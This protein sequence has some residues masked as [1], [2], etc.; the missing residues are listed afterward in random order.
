MSL[1]LHRRRLLK[2]VAGGALV[3]S[4]LAAC[5]RSGGAALP[6]T[7]IGAELAV[8]AAVGGNV[9]AG[10]APDGVLLVDGGF[11][12]EADAVLRAVSATFGRAP[13]QALVNTHWHRGVTGANETLGRQGVKIV[14]HENTKQWLAHETLVRWENKTYEPLPLEA[15]PSETFYDA[16]TLPFGGSAVEMGHMLQ[17]HTDGDIY[18]RFPEQNVFVTGGAVTNDAWPVLDWWTG[19]YIGGTLDAFDK[20][21]PIVDDATVIVP[22]SGP[23]MTKADLKAQSDMYYEIFDRLAALLKDS[24]SP[25]EA[26]EAKPTRGFKEEWGDPDL[27][28]ELAFHSFFGHLRANDRL[29]PMP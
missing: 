13:V 19:G 26:V 5:G 6:V 24:M 21:L 22:G 14:A 18:V 10:R 16:A 1:T 15:R 12:S 17:A 8:I 9:V 25:A 3:A 20:M 11:E 4:P 7:M 23:L 28:V 29:G 27:F 2:A